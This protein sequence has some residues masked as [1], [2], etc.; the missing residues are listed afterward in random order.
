MQL[1]GTAAAGP[2]WRTTMQNML[3]DSSYQQ[4]QR[5]SSIV[6]QPLCSVNG[7]YQEVYIP[8]TEPSD[9]CYIPT[10]AEIEAKQ[11]EEQ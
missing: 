3:G 11:R 1:G 8:N 5:P 9:H 2:I 4:F 10:Q 7:T 6:Q